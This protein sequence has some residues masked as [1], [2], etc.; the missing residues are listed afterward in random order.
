MQ[1]TA[2]DLLIQMLPLF[3]FTSLPL[4]IGAFYLAPKLGRNRWLWSFFLLI[5]GVN[6]FLGYIFFFLAFGTI[7]DR[8]NAITERMKSAATFT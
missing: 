1:P 5:P 8:L 7:L 4:A 2:A 6:I 3:L